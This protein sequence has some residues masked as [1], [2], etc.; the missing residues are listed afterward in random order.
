M[1]QT[2]KLS[3]SLAYFG[4]HNDAVKKQKK[5]RFM[6][7]ELP[8]RSCRKGWRD[9]DPP[10]PGCLNSAVERSKMICVSD[11]FA[12]YT[13]RVIEE[14]CH[15]ASP[16]RCTGGSKEKSHAELPRCHRQWQTCFPVAQVRSGKA[17]AVEPGIGRHPWSAT[18]SAK[19][20]GPSQ[21]RAHSF[22]SRR[23]LVQCIATPI[24]GSDLSLM[25]CARDISMT[26]RA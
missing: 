14:G 18:T 17:V 4:G 12:R 24:G 15:T 11:A 19:M 13:L 10:S 7:R 8:Q 16:I 9:F 25:V 20:A 3:R 1:F 2:P 5:S 21:N 6:G 23:T 26:S 22:M